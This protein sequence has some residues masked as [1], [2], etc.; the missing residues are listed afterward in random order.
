MVRLSWREYAWS[1][2]SAWWPA[3]G[4]FLIHHHHHHHHFI[5]QEIMQLTFHQSTA[6][7]R[8]TRLKI[9]YSGRNKEIQTQ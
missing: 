8:I 2:Q 3:S 5:C 7:T 4:H 6:L 1:S 9:T